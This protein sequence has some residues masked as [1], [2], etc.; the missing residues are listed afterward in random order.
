MELGAEDGVRNDITLPQG[1]KLLQ[2]GVCEESKAV[3]THGGREW[4]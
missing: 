2:E 3:A 1:S 4:K